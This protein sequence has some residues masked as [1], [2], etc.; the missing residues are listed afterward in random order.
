M[1]PLYNYMEN[2]WPRGIIC[3]QFQKHLQIDQWLDVILT[4]GSSSMY[5]AIDH[6]GSVLSKDVTIVL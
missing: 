5:L 2:W 4:T 1:V 3:G 6:F